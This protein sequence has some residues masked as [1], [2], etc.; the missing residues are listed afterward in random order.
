[1]LLPI[2]VFSDEIPP[3]YEEA[4]SF[5]DASNGE[6]YSH[7][8]SRPGSRTSSS[9]FFPLSLGGQSKAKRSESAQVRGPPRTR[10]YRSSSDVGRARRAR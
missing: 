4:L 5:G 9:R 10:T 7:R 8:P 6:P 3:G 1:M 2:S